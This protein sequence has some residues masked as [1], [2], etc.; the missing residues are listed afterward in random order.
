MSVLGCFCVC[1]SFAELSKLNF[2]CVKRKK[3]IKNM[4]K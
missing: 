2:E 1:L 4:L 3:K